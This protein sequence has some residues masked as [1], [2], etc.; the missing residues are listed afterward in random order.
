MS[1]WAI[2]RCHR[3]CRRAPA[4]GR[5]RSGPIRPS[6]APAAETGEM[7]DHRRL[8]DGAPLLDGRR[9]ALRSRRWRDSRRSAPRNRASARCWRTRHR[10]GAGSPCRCS[11][12]WPRRSAFGL[13]QGRRKSH[14]VARGKHKVMDDLSREGCGADKRQ[15]RARPECIQPAR[16][17]CGAMRGE[18]DDCGADETDGH[19]VMSQR[20]GRVPS[21]AQSQTR[22]A[23][24]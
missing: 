21:T 19:A 15:T 18:Q 23:A 24:M 13:E 1:Q 22:V 3:Y 2:R 8:V 7:L 4:P 10:T 5:R 16:S 17:R 20:S 9:R 12:G 14:A 6:A 11:P